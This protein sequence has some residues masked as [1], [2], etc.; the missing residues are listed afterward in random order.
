MGESEGVGTTESIK[1][2]ELYKAIVAVFNFLSSYMVGEPDAAKIIDKLSESYY[3][4]INNEVKENFKE[5]K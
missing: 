4:G 2:S 3:K 5:K 1:I